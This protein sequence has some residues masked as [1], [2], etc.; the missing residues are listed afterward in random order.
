MKTKSFSHTRARPY[1]AGHA[2]A[3]PPGRDR[4]SRS[5]RLT[6]AADAAPADEHTIRLGIVVDDRVS[7]AARHL[8]ATIAEAD[9]IWRRHGVTVMLAGAGDFAPDDIRLDAHLRTGRRASRDRSR[10]SDRS[11]STRRECPGTRW[12]SISRRSRRA[13]ST[14][15][16]GGRAFAEWPP[17]LAAQMTG[18]A[19]GRV[20]AHEIGHYLLA[21]PAHARNGLMQAAFNGRDA[22]G[23]GS[24]AVRVGWQ[25]AA[26][27]AS[28]ARPP[29]IRPENARRRAAARP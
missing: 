17:A 27:V 1:D 20:L 28:A 23:V 22:G 4:A 14:P 24:P 7:P 9:A 12:P 5:P 26:A 15:A 25:G 19:L 21:S 10:G 8:A 13:S 2:L 18:R 11:G 6:G 29:R 16:V 3:S